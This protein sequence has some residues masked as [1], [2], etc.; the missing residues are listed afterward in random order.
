MIPVIQCELLECRPRLRVGA[1]LKPYLQ[2][3]SGHCKRMR[4]SLSELFINTFNDTED[5]NF[6]V[7]STCSTR[8]TTMSKSC[9]WMDRHPSWGLSSSGFSLTSMAL[10]KSGAN[11]HGEIFIIHD[12]QVRYPKD[13]VFEQDLTIV[14]DSSRNDNRCA[15]NLGSRPCISFRG[16]FIEMQMMQTLL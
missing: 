2:M 6:L 10:L 5:Y 9:K 8:H 14:L 11:F 7:Y 13:Y 3:T 1:I 15:R 4:K 12:A 16:N